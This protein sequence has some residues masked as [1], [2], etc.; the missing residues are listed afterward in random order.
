M[1]LD[2]T[3]GQKWVWKCKYLYE[4]IIWMFPEAVMLRLCS[5]LNTPMSSSAS[6]EAEGKRAMGPD[7][8]GGAG[9]LFLTSSFLLR[10]TNDWFSPTSRGHRDWILQRKTYLG[11]FFFSFIVTGSLLL[12]FLE[13]WS[14]AG[15]EV[16]AG[17]SASCFF[18]CFSFFF[19]FLSL[20][21]FLGLLVGG[22]ESAASCSWTA[23]S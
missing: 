3:M 10:W 7:G 23:L 6:R 8:G 21:F 17:S 20:S 2:G 15:G 14:I 9:R 5:V 22:W 19:S 13:V 12:L 16:S 18:L 11:F 4:D 1:K